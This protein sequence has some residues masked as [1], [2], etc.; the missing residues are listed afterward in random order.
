MSSSM[1]RIKG[2]FTL[3]GALQTK[4]EGGA[5]LKSKFNLQRKTSVAK[6]KKAG[7]GFEEQDLW[8]AAERDGG[9]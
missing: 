2:Q 1:I 5:D 9:V 6:G 4:L 3:S 7:E 8:E